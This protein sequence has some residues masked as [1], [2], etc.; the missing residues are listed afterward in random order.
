MESNEI[1]PTTHRRAF[2]GTI[3]TGAAAMSFATIAAPL[4]ALAKEKDPY[5]GDDPD[6]WFN[7]LKGKHRM[8]FD[9]P[10]SKGMMPFAWSRVF[11]M[12]NGLT[13]TQEKDTN[14]VV[15]LRHE[16][17]PYA[18][19]SSLW[20]KYK[21]GEVFKINDDVTK[22]SAVRNAFW[23]PMQGDFSIPGIG[24]VAIGINELQ[25]SGVMFCVCNMALTVYSAAVA[26]GMGMDAA[27]VKKEWV[28]GLLPGIQIVP[29]GV[30]AVGRAQE[31][32]C[33]YCYAG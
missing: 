20:T 5:T 29:S 33:A 31:H 11:L 7:K 18:M 19:E 17:I 30:W 8:V 4:Q 1:K 23:K 32:G 25:D 14:V 15:V 24:N 27:A 2:L 6:A 10:E 9:V 13:G 28:D 21:F 16:A 3:A 12:T 22:A 26:Q